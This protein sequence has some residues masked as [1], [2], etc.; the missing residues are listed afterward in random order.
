MSNAARTAITLG[1]GA[2]LVV[3][4]FLCVNYTKAFGV[5]HHVEWA[6]E[7]GMPEPTYGIFLLGAALLAAGGVF[8]GR[9]RRS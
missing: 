4:G 2:A 9:V 5:E 3:A 8:L 1:S 7:H 6:K